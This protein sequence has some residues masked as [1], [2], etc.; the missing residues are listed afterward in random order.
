MYRRPLMGFPRPPP[1]QPLPQ[2]LLRE[3]D[4]LLRQTFFSILKHHNAPMAHK[5]DIVYALAQAWCYSESERDFEMLEAR[6]K[7][8]QPHE[9]I[10]VR[11]TMRS[12]CSHMHHQRSWG[13][14]S[15]TCSTCTT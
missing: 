9:M 12:K 5:V 1:T 15:A 13:A 7:D 3:D 2:V 11:C 14:L 6:I 8:L 4:N 10:L